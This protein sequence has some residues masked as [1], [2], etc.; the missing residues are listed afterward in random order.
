MPIKVQWES[1][2]KGIVY[3]SFEGF[4]LWSEYF[5]SIQDLVNLTEPV[6][7]KR[8]DII[9][10]LRPSKHIPLNII[11]NVQLGSP[12]NSAEAPNWGITVIVGSDNFIKL[13]YTLLSRINSFLAEHYVLSETM[14]DAHRLIE[15]HRQRQIS[16]I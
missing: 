2:E 1:E 5:E 8:I 15:E 3:W 11:K 4:W 7:D 14:E 13:I 9:C 12:K 16:A 6:K 10:D